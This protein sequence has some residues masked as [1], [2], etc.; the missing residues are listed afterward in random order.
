[1]KRTLALLLI[2]CCLL[3]ACGEK[4]SAPRELSVS[5]ENGTAIIRWAKSDEAETYRLFRRSP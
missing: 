4:P 5:L 1:M 3:C 2:V